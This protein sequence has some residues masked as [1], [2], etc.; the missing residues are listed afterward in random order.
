[1]KKS[2]SVLL[3][4]LEVSLAYGQEEL[5]EVKTG[6]KGRFY[7]FWGWNR[8]WYTNSDISFHGNNYDFTL[9]NLKA[10]DR[11]SPFQ[12]NTYFAPDKIS[13]PQTNFRLGYFFN[14]KWDI[15]VG[16]DHMKYVLVYDQETEITGY[17]HD[18]TVFD[19]DYD[20][21][22]FINTYGFLKF[23]HTDGLNYINVEVNRNEDLFDFLK[24]KN[25]PDKIQLNGIVGAGTGILLPKSNVNLWNNVRHD[26]FHVAG[27]GISIG[28][29]VDLILMKYLFIR[30]QYKLG[31]INMPDIRTSPDPA[32]RANQHFFFQEVF[33]SV[34][35][36]FHLH[37]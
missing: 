29:G 31:F 1:M 37:H 30:S 18:G 11:Q 21:Q 16:V 3:L 34:G 6:N 17:I 19:G 5:K 4:I 7:A 2:V 13:L 24:V 32:D 22:E 9:E 23:E 36:T 27:Y 8:S 28:T 33:I 10:T 14:D 35:A 25:N 12:F 20:H 15:S 26:D